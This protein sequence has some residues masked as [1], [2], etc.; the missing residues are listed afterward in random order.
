M[1]LI[2][3]LLLSSTFSVN[4]GFLGKRHHHHHHHREGNQTLSNCY[5]SLITGY[6]GCAGLCD[7]GGCTA[8]APM[9][10]STKEC[11]KECMECLG[12]IDFEFTECEFMCEHPEATQLSE[13]EEEDAASALA[14]RNFFGDRKLD[15]P[16]IFRD[17]SF[18]KKFGKNMKMDLV[19]LSKHH[20]HHHHSE[21]STIH[22][23][24]E[25]MTLIQDDSSET[26]E[27]CLECYDSG[28]NSVS[29]CVDECDASVKSSQIWGYECM[30]KCVGFDTIDTMDD[31]EG[32]GNEDT[33]DTTDN[34]DAS[35]AFESIA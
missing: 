1:N 21:N 29:A 27:S 22:C 2:Y 13:E 20:H 9:E 26:C 5:D 4:G 6:K 14:K 32:Y 24:N 8:P 33:D 10:N 31:D 16:M 3:T 18:F 11:V 34:D 7:C 23:Y 17:M 30:D 15:N 28:T 19:S 35:A 25:F 12:T